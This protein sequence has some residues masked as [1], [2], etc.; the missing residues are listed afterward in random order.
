MTTIKTMTTMN[1]EALLD[2]LYV[3]RSQ[4]DSTYRCFDYLQYVD[5]SASTTID[6]LCRV[7]MTQWC[8]QVVDFIKFNRETVAIAM[9]YLDR[10][11]CSNSTRARKVLQSRPEYQL[12]AMTTLYMAIKINEPVIIDLIF[13]AEMSR[14][15]YEIS[16]FNQ[17]EMDILTSLSWRL[18]G[19]SASSFVEHFLTLMSYQGQQ[20]ITIM[21]MVKYDIEISIAEYKLISQ[22][23]SVIAAAAIL[24]YIENGS[25]CIINDDAKHTFYQQFDEL[26]TIT[27]VDKSSLLEARYILSI[28]KDKTSLENTAPARPKPSSI[29]GSSSEPSKKCSTSDTSNKSSAWLK[30][31]NGPSPNCISKRSLSL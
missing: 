21:D 5:V 25:D 17:M 2:R 10:F 24:N 23:T 31:E 28:L 18:N 15:S 9:S 8:Y 30:E 1:Q 4:E 16:D 12:A 26:L 3:M 29:Q 11:L 6:A 13:L 14:G 27:N 7:K 22:K 20:A 19:P